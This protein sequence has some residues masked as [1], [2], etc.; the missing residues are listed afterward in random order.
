MAWR[1]SHLDLHTPPLTCPVTNIRHSRTRAAAAGYTDCDVTLLFESK[2][3]S[4]RVYKH[5]NI[6][7][8]PDS[9]GYGSVLV[10][11]PDD[12]TH[13]LI[14]T[15]KQRIQQTL[16]PLPL[17][18]TLLSTPPPWLPPAFSGAAPPSRQ[19]APRHL[20][21]QHGNSQARASAHATA[22]HMLC[23]H[24]PTH[25]TATLTSHPCSACTC[26][27]TAQPGSHP[28][29]ACTP[30][31]TAHPRLSHC[32]PPHTPYPPHTHIH[33]RLHLPRAPPF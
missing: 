19:Q 12:D 30:L 18:L 17:P 16:L 6:L 20:V 9:Y 10:G 24:P 4:P 25:S 15:V 23:M 29:S 7:L 28:C 3:L 31:P 33:Q 32:I 11:D 26:L 14:N 1:G 2:I 21:V 27:P 5:T 22:R 13:T 8:H